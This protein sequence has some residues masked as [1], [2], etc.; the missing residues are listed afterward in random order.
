ME[1]PSS[2][3]LNRFNLMIN[4]TIHDGNE[5]QAS[6]L[7]G[8]SSNGTIILNSTDSNEALALS[9]A[10][11]ETQSL[12]A[13]TADS[14]TNGISNKSAVPCKV[15]GDKASGYH[16]GVTS[17]EGCKGFF[18]RSIQ[19]QI[20]YR[21]L[22]DGKCLVIRLNRNRCQYCRFKK[23]LAV[24]MSRDSVRYGRVPKRTR[25]INANVISTTS[26]TTIS[27]KSSNNNSKSCTTSNL[28]ASSPAFAEELSEK[29]GSG[30]EPNTPQMCPSVANSPPEVL[31][32][33]S[34]T[35]TTSTNFVVSAAD[36][37]LSVY[38]V[39]L[40]VSQAH[41]AFCTYTDEHIRTLTR[42]PI[43]MPV[44]EN[45]EDNNVATS[46]TEAL[47]EQKIFLWQQF[48][49]H[50]TPDVQKIV[51]FAKRVPGFC[52]FTQDDQLILIKLGFFELWLSH[53]AKTTTDTS[54]TFDDGT[55]LTRQQLEIMY[56]V[57]FVNDLISFTNGLNACALSDTEIGLYTALVLMSSDRAGTQDQ[58]TI[59][60]A[61]E[62]IAE[63]LRVQIIRSRPNAASA[64]LQTLPALEAKIQELRSLGY[65]HSTHLD[66]F[67]T[68][69][70][71]VARLPPL[72]AEIFDIPKAE[73][74]LLQQ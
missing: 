62:R 28:A 31:S 64:A 38:D 65:R 24:G 16:Y 29:V 10:T 55:Y 67:R 58:K 48:A 35:T 46:V 54:L 69:H 23:C 6:S 12:V 8:T 1:Y 52:D 33:S 22:R 19:K 42:Y 4:I 15:C 37:E 61:R 43:T 70:W 34:T 17:C 45:T 32:P 66:W 57:D 53:I 30:S 11:D 40:C 41:H 72:F 25:E 13:A 56:D 63:A 74:D 9:T 18:R 36:H 47:E 27:S 44:S 20:E 7:E 21:C 3:D 59:V 73:D 51:E 39:I 49:Q 5:S 50:M 14:N 68:Q 71:T 60:R 2:D 26:N